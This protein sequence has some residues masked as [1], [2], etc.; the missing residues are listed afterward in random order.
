MTGICT[1]L[2][3]TVTEQFYL[4]AKKHNRCSF[5]AY[6]CSSTTDH[7][8]RNW[9][10]KPLHWWWHNSHS[11][12]CWRSPPFWNQQ[13]VKHIR[14]PLQHWQTSLM[15]NWFTHP[16]RY[17]PWHQERISIHST[18][19]YLTYT[20]RMY[21]WCLK[22]SWLSK[23]VIEDSFRVFIEKLCQWWR[24]CIQQVCK[25]PWSL[26]SLEQFK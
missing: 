12:L 11:T 25:E 13:W 21:L 5:I 15:S 20:I 2:A 6:L 22:W 24:F 19:N 18:I 23:I 3:L 8:L 14:L 10:L 17:P 26:A 7:R 9:H 1:K 4:S 16:I